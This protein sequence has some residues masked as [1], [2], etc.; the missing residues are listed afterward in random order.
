MRDFGLLD[1]SSGRLVEIYFMI[2]Y[3]FKSVIFCLSSP[4]F[5]STFM[6]E[7][8]DHGSRPGV[9]ALPCPQCGVLSSITLSRPVNTAMRTDE[10]F[11]IGT[12]LITSVDT[13]K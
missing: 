12:V 5:S 2:L 10:S 11:S 3:C 8:L 7:V 1:S 9:C 6:R 13:L 4:P